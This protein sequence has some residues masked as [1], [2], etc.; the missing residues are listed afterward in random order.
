[1]YMIVYTGFKSH[2]YIL[3]VLSKYLVRV[4][5]YLVHVQTFCFITLSKMS[6]IA[7][8]L[9]FYGNTAVKSL[10]GHKLHRQTHQ[11]LTLMLKTLKELF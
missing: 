3:H 1:M 8:S 11:F 7:L 9:C 10:F 6:F 4:R 2:F 5:M